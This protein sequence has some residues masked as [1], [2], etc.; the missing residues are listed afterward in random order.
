M[1]PKT[2]ADSESVLAHWSGVADLNALGTV[3]GGVILKLIDEAA[4]LAANRH[5]RQACVTGGFDRVS[6]L[7]PVRAAELVTLT[8]V[9]TAVWKSS[10]E[11]VVNV[12]AENPRR[13]EKRHTCTAYVTMV[14]VD[15]LGQPQPV[16]P[17][18]ATNA[19]EEQLMRE[20]QLRRE[21]RL[22]ERRQIEQA[23]QT[24]TLP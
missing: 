20:A 11:V 24:E 19:L 17:L 10:M 7:H 3:H 16:T 8:A 5:S 12:E 14:A 13:G 2:P 1:E 23:R 6:F 4:A 21:N 15:D 18:V 22:A 9:V